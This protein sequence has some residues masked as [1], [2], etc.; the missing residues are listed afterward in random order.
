MAVPASWAGARGRQRFPAHSCPH[1][2]EGRTIKILWH[3]NAPFAPTGYGSQT[4]LF[5]PLIRDAGH[6]VAI[7]AFWGVGGSRIE[8]EG[9]T[10]YPADR[11]YGNEWLP[12]LAADHGGGDA[13]R[14]QVITL[15]DV[16]VLR[17]KL[18]RELRVA[19]WCPVD[20]VPVPP[21][22]LHYFEQTAATPIAMSR[23]GEEQLQ[24]VG[25]EPLYV[26]HGIDTERLRPLPR[27]AF[28]DELGIDQEAFVVGMVAANKGNAPARK[29][30][31]AAFNAFAIFYK[32]H[33]NSI[34]YLHTELD[35]GAGG[36]NI[37]A[38]L[39]LCG[40]PQSAVR[41]T[42]QSDLFMGIEYDKLALVYSNL[43]VLLQP[44]YGEG[45]GI[46]IVE[47][48]ACGTPVI[49]NDFSAMPE[50]CGAGWLVDG[51]AVAHESQGA[52]WQAPSIGSIIDALENAHANAA[53]MRDQ[54]RA[55]ALG[56][57]VRKVMT[58]HWL[59]VL[60][61]L[62]RRLGPVP[63]RPKALA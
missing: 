25:L 63:L 21:S 50:L 16:W 43:D 30:F 18:L 10:V 14:V 35:G 33:P 12:V 34:L 2:S 47:A 48:Q 1:L 60:A 61:E 11:D 53:G 15:M 20:H 22:V 29:A 62:E 27:H 6:D 40:V 58:D 46:P 49:V 28:R 44:S 19:S 8:W 57:D 45:F 39:D 7:S 51:I 4:G 3:S 32:Q 24:M 23:F 17:S 26:P 37:P 42:P 31:P 9:M 5:T 36:I 59:P 41:V 38:W 54:A 55:F 56:Y 52:W 13:S